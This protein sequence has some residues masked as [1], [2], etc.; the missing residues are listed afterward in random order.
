MHC[1]LVSSYGVIM[2]M[3]TLLGFLSRSVFL[4]ATERVA[5]DRRGWARGCCDSGSVR[6]EREGYS[7]G[8]KAV[9]A[10][11]T[12]GKCLWL[13]QGVWWAEMALFNYLSSCPS[14]AGGSLSVLEASGT[15][16]L[17]ELHCWMD[18]STKQ[19]LH[20]LFAPSECN[21]SLLLFFFFLQYALAQRINWVLCQ[22]WTSS[23]GPFVNT[24]RTVRW[25]WVTWRSPA[26]IAVVTCP[27]LG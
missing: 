15:S 11:A 8:S 19:F 1:Q 4:A 23:I 9:P 22:T 21:F 24:M 7:L 6:R 17:I 14:G 10:D 18:W 26:S 3:L 13:V 16:G 25:W 5:W 27:S 12:D 2:H 20:L